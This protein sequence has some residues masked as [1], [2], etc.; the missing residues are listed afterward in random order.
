MNSELPGLLSAVVTILS[1]L[2]FFYMGTRVAAARGKHGIK[3]PATTGHPE[4]DRAVRVHM[5]TLE[6]LVVF[7]PLLWLATVYFHWV[8]WLP[9]VMGVV[10]I[11]GRL[12]YMQAYMADPDKRGT[13]FGITFFAHVVLLIMA[14]AGIVASWSAASA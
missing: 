7:L 8:G 3:A 10:W 1:L 4:M 11:I 12:M 6:Q 14:V 13:G 5:N 9:A 2:V